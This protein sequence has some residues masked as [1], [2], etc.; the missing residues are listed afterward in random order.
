MYQRWTTRR[1]GNLTWSVRGRGGWGERIASRYRKKVFI[2]AVR[3]DAEFT[4]AVVTV[5]S[6]I[7]WNLEPSVEQRTA[8]EEEFRLSRKLVR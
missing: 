7:F 5:F 4:M 2:P 6:P 1:K 3:T 8:L